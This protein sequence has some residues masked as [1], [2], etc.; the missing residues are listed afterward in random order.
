MTLPFNARLSAA[1]T[2]SAAF[3]PLAGLTQDALSIYHG[4]CEIYGQG[5]AAGTLYTVEFGCV[6]I[7]RI[8]SEGRR[9]VAGFCFAG[10]VFGWE[11]DEDH[12]FFAE[13]VEVT[14]LRV[15]RPS[16]DA[17]ASA[18]LLPL[19]LKSLRRFQ[20]HLLV[21]GGTSVDERFAAF[22]CQLAERQGGETLVQ[23]PMPRSDIGDYLGVSF[24]TVSRIL[25]RLKE[26]GIVRTPDTHS[27]EI[28]DLP[29]LHDICRQ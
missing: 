11:S 19:V 10:D 26:G 3:V 20:Q 4:N 29:R 15:V 21:L 6:R 28:L 13:A 8:T 22:L 5:E 18:M 12:E 24:E 2:A 17:D 14:G 27:V 16:R 25:R 7:G 1:Q 23:L 9:Q